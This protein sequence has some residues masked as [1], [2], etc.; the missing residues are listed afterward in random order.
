MYEKVVF[1]NPFM[2]KYCYNGFKSQ[3]ICDKF[4]DDFPAVSNL[5]RIGFLQVKI[6]KT[7]ILLCTQMMLYSLLM[8][9]LLLWHFAVMKWLFLV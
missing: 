8:K 7:Y 3:E 2:L 4:V 5:F 6:L 1:E 9:I